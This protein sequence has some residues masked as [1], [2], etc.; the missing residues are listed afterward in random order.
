MLNLGIT[1]DILI[2]NIKEYLNSRQAR[3]FGNL[4]LNSTIKYHWLILTAL[5]HFE[6]PQYVIL[7]CTIALC[8]VMIHA[9]VAW[10]LGVHVTDFYVGD[11]EGQIKIRE[12]WYWQAALFTFAAPYLN[13]CL[14]FSMWEC[15]LFS[16][17]IVNCL[18]VASSMSKSDGDLHKAGYYW[19]HWHYKFY[20][21]FELNLRKKS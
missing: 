10:S 1:L 18:L 5:I 15:E 7:D 20:H 11:F 17:S 3:Q 6:N 9:F 12:T 8:S 14:A 13:I 16:T 4:V 2:L 19:E 21:G